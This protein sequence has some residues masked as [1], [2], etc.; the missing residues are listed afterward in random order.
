MTDDTRELG[1]GPT[2]GF[3]TLMVLFGALGLNGNVEGV[4][5][6]WI[7]VGALA[8]MIV[9]ELAMNLYAMT[10]REPSG[11]AGRLQAD[12]SDERAMRDGG[13]QQNGLQD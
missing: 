10:D 13:E 2:I 6:V 9:S 4:L 1:N 7:G 5:V 3:V 8:F 12:E 11:A